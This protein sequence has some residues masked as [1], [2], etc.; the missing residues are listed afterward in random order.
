MSTQKHD[1]NVSPRTTGKHFSRASRRDR[2]VPAIVYGNIE[3][4]NVVVEE[5]AIVK[6]NTRAYENSLFTLKSEDKKVDGKVALLKDIQVHP[7]TRRPLHL[8]IFVLDMT[9]TVRVHVEI[10]LEGKA[11]GLSEGGLL[12]QVNRQIEVE[13]LP[14]N[15]P[16]FFTMDVSNLGVGQALHVSDLELPEGIKAISSSDMTI[17]VVN[18]LEE[19]VAAPVAAAAP[20]EGAAAPA[21]GAAATAAPAADAKKAEKK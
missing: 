9:K 17:A 13:C 12:N 4:A 1:L 19:E 3:N 7:V 2:K 15:I 5:G 10:R 20:T 21:A 8:D 11:I 18:I 16:S 6:F 14:T